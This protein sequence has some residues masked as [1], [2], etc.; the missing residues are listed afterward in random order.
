L[1]SL[2]SSELTAQ[3]VRMVYNSG[4]EVVVDLYQ[5]VDVVFTAKKKPAGSPFDVEFGA[6]VADSK[7]ISKRIPGFYNDRNEWVLRFSS[8]IQGTYSFHTF[9]TLPELSGLTGTMVVNTKSKP[10]KHGTVIVDP[11]NPQHFSY[12]DGTSYFALA[13]ELDWLFAL[14]Y[15]NKQGIPKTEKLIGEVANNGSIRW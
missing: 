9:S 6:S 11:A 1:I 13:F 12:E 2:G 5:V 10:D 14:D 15:H 7:G 8:N 4:T 3:P